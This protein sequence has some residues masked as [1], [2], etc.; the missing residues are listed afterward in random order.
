LDPRRSIRHSSS[1]EKNDRID[2]KQWTA[3]ARHGYN[4]GAEGLRWVRGLDVDEAV[5]FVP[6]R[7]GRVRVTSF[8]RDPMFHPWDRFRRLLGL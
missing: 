7:A 3:N 1:D 2:E 8:W 5:G 4:G 6:A